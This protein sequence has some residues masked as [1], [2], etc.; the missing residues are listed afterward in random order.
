M[1]RFKGDPEHLT[2]AKIVSFI[3]DLDAEEVILDARDWLEVWAR[4]PQ[5]WKGGDSSGRYLLIGETR[6]RGR[7]GKRPSVDLSNDRVMEDT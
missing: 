4:V 2:F 6:V 5:E 7:L 3:A 1:I